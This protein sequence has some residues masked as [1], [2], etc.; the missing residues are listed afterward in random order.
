MFL[1]LGD[2]LLVQY[3]EAT[4]PISETSH[5]RISTKNTARE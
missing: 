3:G 5:D 4:Q 2:S 1:I